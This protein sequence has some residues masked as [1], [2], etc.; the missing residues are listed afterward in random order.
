MDR[1]VNLYLFD[2]EVRWRRH[3][4]APTGPSA[5][6]GW[7]AGTRTLR[8]RLGRGHGLPDLG[9]CEGSR[10]QTRI[11][12]ADLDFDNAVAADPRTHGQ[13]QVEECELEMRDLQ[14]LRRDSDFPIG[15]KTC[16]AETAAKRLPGFG[17]G[18]DEN[19]SLNS[20]HDDLFK[21]HDWFRRSGQ[22][23]GVG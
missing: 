20:E 17:G 19:R 4:A 12:E 7:S 15:G 11:T 10:R 2:M 18:K 23:P 5:R 13:R 14:P 3:V 21:E 6:T 16:P 22:N 1:R 9:G 8:P